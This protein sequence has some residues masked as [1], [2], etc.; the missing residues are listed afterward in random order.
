MTTIIRDV[1]VGLHVVA[2]PPPPGFF[3]TV[4]PADIT[5]VTKRSILLWPIAI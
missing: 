5:L 3:L 4:L 1:T 2:P